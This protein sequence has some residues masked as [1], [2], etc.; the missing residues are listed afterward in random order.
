[1][2]SPDWLYDSRV[3][4][5]TTQTFWPYDQVAAIGF[6]FGR[7]LHRLPGFR[8]EVLSGQAR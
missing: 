7:V 5:G 1:M 3:R 2:T 4:T 8:A 6:R